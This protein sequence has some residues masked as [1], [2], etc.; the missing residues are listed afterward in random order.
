MEGFEKKTLRHK[1]CHGSAL[2]VSFLKTRKKKKKKKSNKSKT[3]KLSWLQNIYSRLFMG[4]FKQRN[5]NSV[6]RFI[7]FCDA[8]RIIGNVLGICSRSNIQN[9]SILVYSICHIP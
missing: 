3:T 9:V 5:K 6:F 2:G 8:K 4:S 7:H 1:N